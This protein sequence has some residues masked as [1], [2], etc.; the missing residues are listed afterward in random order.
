M[1]TSGGGAYP[2]S[3]SPSAHEPITPGHICLAPYRTVT[4]EQFLLDE[5][6]AT[7]RLLVDEAVPERELVGRIASENLFQYPTT[8]MVKNVA[9]VIVRRLSEGS[10]GSARASI[11]EL[12]ARAPHIEAAQA[13]LYVMMRSYRVVWE[14]MTG[15]VADRYRSQDLHLPRRDIVHVLDGLAA[16]EPDVAAWSPST[17]AK[18]VQVLNASLAKAG[19]KDSI[20]SDALNHLYISPELASCMR[21]IGDAAT[22]WAFDCGGGE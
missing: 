11:L 9:S 14:F 21:L 18:T 6:R 13:N 16:H 8:R 2:E 4:R 5:T 17:L 3:S 22:L 10:L 7:A 15:L 19:I 12:L 1:K 20:R